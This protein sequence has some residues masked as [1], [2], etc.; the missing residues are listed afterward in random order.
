MN[1]NTEHF[2]HPRK[3]PWSPSQSTLPQS[4]HPAFQKQSLL[5]FLLPRVSLFCLFWSFIYINMY[6]LY[7]AF[8]TQPNSFKIIHIVQYISIS[9]HSTSFMADI[10]FKTGK[11]QADL[12]WVYWHI[13]L[14]KSWQQTC[15]HNEGSK[16]TSN[17]IFND[18]TPNTQRTLPP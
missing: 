16:I 12:Y 9:V 18:S 5:L 3:F 17:L 8:F 11:K 14:L 7:F 2:S 10:F 15:S 4:P 6:F 13:P 1:I